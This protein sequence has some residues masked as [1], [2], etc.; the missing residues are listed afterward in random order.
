MRITKYFII[1]LSFFFYVSCTKIEVDSNLTDINMSKD[2]FF[3]IENLKVNDR[4]LYIYNR[5]KSFNEEK[6]FV[7]NLNTKY[8]YPQ[9]DKL[10]VLEDH[11]ANR[12][13]EDSTTLI[14]LPLST[15]Q[16]FISGVILG[17]I[18]DTSINLEYLTQDYIFKLINS[19]SSSKEE[20]EKYLTLFLYLENKLF[21]KT[22]F[23]NIPS[24]Y[25]TNT[26]NINQF[27]RK[28]ISINNVGEI[29]RLSS[30]IVVCIRYVCPVCKGDDPNCPLGGSWSVCYTLSISTPDDGGGIY[31]PSIPEGGGS[32]G[33]STPPCQPPILNWYDKNAPDLP[34]DPCQITNSQ[35]NPYH[36]DTL[37]LD[38]SI[39]NNF[40]CVSK[41]I[42]TV[43]NFLNANAIA[44]VALREI[45]NINRLIR[46]NLKVDWSLTKD[47]R[48]AETDANTN[49]Y[50]ELEYSPTIR[51]N[52]WV[53]RNSSNI[54][55]ASTIIHEVLHAYIYYMRL[56]LNNNAITAQTFANLF[57][58]YTPLLANY[59][60]VFTISGSIS[61]HN[62]IAANLVNLI[63]A[64]LHNFHFNSIISNSKKD[65]IINAL[66]WG[67]LSKTDTWNLRSD[68]SFIKAM[69]LANRDSSLN[70]P[71]LINNSNSTESFYFDSKS[72]KLNTGCN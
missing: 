21:S 28:E 53:L 59:N 5:L 38:T 45:F 26:F 16:E 56:Q 63:S 17:Q 67:G 43:N 30:S 61:Q 72:L 8:G 34:Q 52:P 15:N 12:E 50:F 36:A 33:S 22:E 24:K 13:V 23:S 1:L 9:W 66:A 25:Y 40:P 14:I 18:S 39:S 62:V 68:T 31:I 70:M 64:P 2:K 29:E 35:Y 41:I 20:S 42:D 60:G 3:D 49:T 55:I 51:L 58:I 47:S 27:G 7:E 4:Q 65:S 6:K 10:I 69:N 71:I 54:Y 32:G 57:P 19:Y 46:A 11:K 44:Q 37:I 48:D